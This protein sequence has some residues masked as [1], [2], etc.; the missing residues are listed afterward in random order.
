LPWKHKAET[1][2]FPSFIDM[3]AGSTAGRSDPGETIMFINIGAQGVQFAAVAARAY[4]LA[5][6][7][8]MG[9]AMPQEAFLQDIRD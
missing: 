5:R 3:L 8:G 7:R 2:H 1:G 6:Q 9:R 4:E